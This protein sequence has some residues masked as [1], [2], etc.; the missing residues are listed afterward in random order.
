MIRL[1]VT[2]VAN[3]LCY[4]FFLERLVRY[5]RPR[6]TT[7]CLCKH[8][9]IYI[10]LLLIASCHTLC[11]TSI[12]SFTLSGFRY[13]KFVIPYTTVRRNSKNQTARVLES[14]WLYHLFIRSNSD[15]HE[16]LRNPNWSDWI[17]SCRS[18]IWNS[19]YQG[20]LYICMWLVKNIY[21]W[22]AVWKT[23]ASN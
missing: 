5:L 21:L 1:G 3:L 10:E 4:Y 12:M 20:L 13:F 22:K 6:L 15:F 8:T 7:T 14:L 9:Y 23:H 16:V 2:R 17:H 19:C 11:I 18:Q